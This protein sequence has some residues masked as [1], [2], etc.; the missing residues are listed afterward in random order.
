MVLLI[1]CWTDI[2]TVSPG[3][4]TRRLAPGVSPPPKKH[5]LVMQTGKQI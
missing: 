1:G 3:E 2:V 5:F 4:I